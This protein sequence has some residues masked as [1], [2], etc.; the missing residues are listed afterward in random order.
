MA[1]SARW[2]QAKAIDA[3]FSYF[4][5]NKV[6]NP[7]IVAPTGCHAPGQLIRMADGTCKKIEQL[8]IGDRLLSTAG[9]VIVHTLYAGS[10]QMYDII[11]VKGAPFRVNGDHILSLKKVSKDCKDYKNEPYVVNISVADYLAKSAGWKHYFKLYRAEATEYEHIV[12]TLPIEP[13]SLGSLLGDGHLGTHVELSGQ[14]PESL[15]Y[16]CAWAMQKYEC[17][18]QEE[19][20]YGN[21]N[22]LRVHLLN[23]APV[24]QYLRAVGLMPSK[25]ETKFIPQEYMLS[26]VANRLQLLAG[27]LDTAG[28][29]TKGNFDITFKSKQLL[30]QTVELARSVGLAAYPAVKVISAGT[31]YRAVISGHV[32]SIP[33]KIAR[34]QATQR[35]QIKDVLKTGFTVK[36]A[37]VGQ[38]YG[39]GVTGNQLYC[40]D[41]FTVTHNSGKTHILAGF[42]ARAYEQFPSESILILSHVRE[43]LT[44]DRD[45]LAKYIPADK[46][47]VFSTGL[48]SHQ[49]TKQF[50]IASIQSVYKHAALFQHVRLII[51]DEAHLV[52]AKGQ[53]RYRTFLEAMP[54]ARALGLTATPYRLGTGKLTDP[55]H[56]FDK[57]VYDVNI[58]KLVNEGFLAKLSC[59][60]TDYRLNVDNVAVVGGDYNKKDLSQAVDREVI[61]RA[62][63]KELLRYKESRKSWL[64]FTIDI[65]HCDHTVQCLTEFGITAAAVHSKIGVD[66][67]LILDMFK[68]QDFQALVSVETLTTGFDAPNVDMLVLM[69]PTQSPVLHV[70]MIGRGMRIFP[71]KAECLVLDFAGNIQ[72]LGPIDDVQVPDPTKKKKKGKQPPITKTCPAC[73]EIVAAQA[74]RCITCGHEF[75]VK[76]ALELRPDEE[77][78][79][80]GK[81]EPYRAK[82]LRTHYQLYTKLDSQPT[83]KATYYLGGVKFVHKWLAFS[84]SGYARRTAE[85]WWQRLAGTPI[86]ASSEEA[87]ERR[88]EI[89]QPAALTLTVKGRYTDILAYE[90]NDEV[91]NVH[92]PA[93]S[94]T[95]G[96]P[97]AWSRS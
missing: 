82:V 20:R 37:G 38:Y 56:L 22:F 88:D 50:T 2:Y 72:R 77:H 31:Y 55:P 9:P 35:Q 81:H 49:H 85:L 79:P 40:L 57:V 91:S 5:F 10:A 84:H 58:Q 3:V 90:V 59:K 15:N 65:A 42:I 63:V 17:R 97:A 28:C 70:Q 19:R 51:I 18:I 16:F 6:G 41:D 48:K 93:A 78:S 53:G 68:Q 83:L 1:T 36:P 64:I 67:T 29:Y 69:R 76:T 62:I 23:A 47:G 86:P 96:S 34:K 75:P 21:G 30:D 66:N 80:L 95:A 11:P 32:D 61:T 39:V 7:L 24:L 4:K 33:T 25:S 43:I 54:Q 74:R 73:H 87:Y 27:L 71:G 44:Q 13:Y 52:P 89:K 26:T 46:I 8:K 14:D 12:Q 94:L 45:T 60:A 92:G